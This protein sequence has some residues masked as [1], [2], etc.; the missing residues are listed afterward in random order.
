MYESILRTATNNGNFSLKFTT[1]PFPPTFD[2]W[3][4][5]T[6]FQA[7]FV[8]MFMGACLGVFLTSIVSNIISERIDGLKHLQEIS[9]LSKFE[10]WVGNFLVDYFKFMLLVLGMLPFLYILEEGQLRSSCFIF[11]AMPFALIPFTYVSTFVFKTDSTAQTSTIF[12]HFFNLGILGAIC[13]YLRLT[14]G[15]EVMGDMMM[16]ILKLNPSF[17]VA[18]TITCDTSCE[19]IAFERTHSRLS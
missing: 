14:P 4:E 5:N 3:F 7:V 19:L 2:F 9:G 16:N 10:Y 11:I 18:S 6:S 1:T 17:L 15:N 13:G 12:F 8:S